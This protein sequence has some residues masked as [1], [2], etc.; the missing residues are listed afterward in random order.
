[1]EGLS[2]TDSMEMNTDLPKASGV[3]APKP[4]TT[5]RR[6]IGSF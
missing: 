6:I 1:M 4:V 3:T 2:A 5:T